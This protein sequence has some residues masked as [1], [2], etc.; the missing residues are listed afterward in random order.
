MSRFGEWLLHG[1][2][3]FATEF[4]G[5]AIGLLA[6]VVGGYVWVTWS[7]GYLALAAIASVVA[8]VWGGVAV[9]AHQLE[10]RKDKEEKGG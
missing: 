7:S 10:S 5:L 9:F 4:L 2:R 3:D 6:I 8:V 1:I